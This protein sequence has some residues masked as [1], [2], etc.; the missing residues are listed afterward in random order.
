MP[1]PIAESASSR[2]EPRAALPRPLSRNDACARAL[3]APPSP[4]RT[5]RP[6]I[7]GPSPRIEMPH[8]AIADRSGAFPRHRRVRSDGQ[9]R[10]GPRP[11]Q[12]SRAPRRRETG[13]V[14]LL[15]PTGPA[16]IGCG[17]L[18]FPARGP[19]PDFLVVYLLSTCCLPLLS[20]PGSP[21]AMTWRA[22]WFHRFA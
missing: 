11:A 8:R 17:L 7:T 13:C 1:R 12:L 15:P 14:P 16:S 10:P 3:G 18:R 21:S 4:I 9:G 20:G 19:V 22:A 2:L 6:V 5:N